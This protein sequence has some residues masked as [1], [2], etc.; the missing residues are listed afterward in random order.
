MLVSLNSIAQKT[1]RGVI[2]DSH[3]DEVIPFV[4]ILFKGTG[5]GTISDSAGKFGLTVSHW[6]S[7][8][9]EFTRVGFQPF[10]LTLSKDKTDFDIN[11]P[12]ERGTL[13]AGVVV[14]IKID[15]G[16]FLWKKI[17]QHK[18][19]NN[20]YR[21]DNFSYELYNKLE[22]DVKNLKSIQRIAN[23][24]PFRPI[25]D[26][27]NQNI[28]TS[29]GKKVLPT[30][31]TEAISDYYYQKKPLKRREEIKAVNTL[32]IKNESMI[33]FL[34]GMDQ[35]INVYNNYINVFTKEFI[36]PI[37]DNGDFY[38]KY[39]V[40]DTQKVGDN[41]YYHLLFI[42]RRKGM[43]TFEGD[44]WVHAG[45]FAIQKINLYLDKSADINFLEKLSYMQEYS[46]L[47]DGG[48]FIAREKLV[49]DVAPLNN[50][51]PGVI[52]RKTSTYKNIV[53]NDTSVVQKL[54]ANKL[55]EE[56]ITLAGANDKARPYWDTARHVSLSP[57][58]KGIIR[59]IDTIINTPSYKKITK[60]IYFIASGYVEVGNVELGSA[61]NWFSGNGW[62]GF[63]TRFDV[64]SNKYFHKKLRYHAYLAYGFGD[65]KVKGQAEVF[66]LP[67]KEPRQ[68]WYV[69][70][71]NDLD[72]GQNYYGEISEDNIFSFAIRK[73]NIP[74]KYMLLEIKNAEFFN[75]LRSGFS[76]LVS[77]ANKSY[78]PLKNLVPAD[79]FAVG[80]ER[81]VS[82]E[83]SLKLRF[84]YQEKFIESQFFR[85]SLGS[86]Y[87]IVEATI[88]QAIPNLFNSKY[89]YTKVNASIFDYINVPPFGYVS[90][91]IFGG[92]TFGAAPY[93][94]LDVAPGNELYYYN[95]YAYNMMNRYEFVHDQFMG[96]NFE[97]NIGNG[98]FR[99]FPKLKIR[100]FYT[101]KALWG[102][103]STENKNLN[104][105]EGH[106][107]QSLDGKTYLELGT[108][109]DNIFRFLRIDFIWR[110]LPKSNLKSTTEKFG[111]F[112]SVRVNF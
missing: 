52:G 66:Y 30:Y 10:Y 48:W 32:G 94:F 37:S 29:E 19:E 82:T 51:A 78:T 71:R 2:R 14:K 112:G 12:M 11:I 7:D 84:A 17:V 22:V 101:V 18:P 28:D 106:N 60:E 80:L 59:M 79:S 111:I 57:T 73:P 109:I 99:I 103:L 65:K 83:V 97:H 76:T 13:N 98:I 69:G 4:S 16:L 6:P 46:R 1:I 87:P 34:G 88:T 100:Q 77:V 74:R 81:L 58:E 5:V 31:L 35:V 33:K 107:F 85:T 56:V 67:K 20:R 21:F 108:G 27:I 86:Q 90:Y 110:L 75:E 42:P 70:Y 39:S 64:A 92:K 54:A 91:Q 24:K 68:Y 63:R 53:V 61:Y 45:T 105:K 23:I 102:S 3:N 41:R 36:S 26:L 47:P 15:K 62:E 89:R 96:V 104:F 49:A 38:Y 44:C 25:N 93:P 50:K 40:S 9:L 95:K 8:T 43:N 72:F 55:Q